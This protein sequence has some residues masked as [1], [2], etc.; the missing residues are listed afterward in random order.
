[1]QSSSSIIPVRISY[2]PA[3]L[4][5]GELYLPDTST[6]QPLVTIILIHGGYW[7][8]RYDLTLMNRL[9]EDLARRGYAAWNIEYRRVGNDGGGWPG[10]FLDVARAADYVKVLAPKYNL[11]VQR[12]V[13]I[14]HSAGG[15]LAFWLAA[16]KQLPSDSPLGGLILPENQE[17]ESSEPLPLTGV[18]SL[19]GV[20][21][22]EMAWNLHLSNDAVVE[23]LG[24]SFPDAP[25]RY[26]QTSPRSLLPLGLPQVLIHGTNDMNVPIEISRNYTIAAKERHDPVTY[27]ELEN[28]DH[29]DVIDPQSKAWEATIQAL[30][31]MLARQ[32]GSPQGQ[33]C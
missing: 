6:R 30:T 8:A 2:G 19:A 11:D 25:E 9:G 21:D 1:M 22:L 3:Y 5:F 4:Q 17:H 23:L 15:H 29:F 28:T 10:T 18:I 7:R 32:T 31:E 26:R 27:I 16:R 14:G 24:A 20:L 13:P 12:V 33:I